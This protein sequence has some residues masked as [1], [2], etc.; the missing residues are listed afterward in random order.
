VPQ[1]RTSNAAHLQHVI[2]EIFKRILEFPSPIYLRVPPTFKATSYLRLTTI[3]SFSL[4]HI[5]K[6]M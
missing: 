1:A 6:S 3:S 5:L 4:P 2:R